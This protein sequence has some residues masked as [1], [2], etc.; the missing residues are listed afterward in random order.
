MILYDAIIRSLD[1]RTGSKSPK[2]YAYDPAKTWPEADGFD[3]L[4]QKEMAFELGGE[5][6]PSVN[7]TCVTNDALFFEGN[8]ILVY[9]EDLPNIHKAAPYA[10]IT[11]LL[12][13]DLEGEEDDR[14]AAHRAIQSMD[15]V[16]YHL[17]PKGFMMRSSGFG[18]REQVRVSKAAVREGISFE[19]VGNTFIRKYLENEN[20]R[21]VKEIFLTAP[22]ADYKGLINTAREVSNLTSSLTK[23]LDG[24]PTDCDTCSIR[25][26]CDQIDG[27]RELHFGGKAPV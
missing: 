1:G 16:K 14:E 7:F 10:R 17:Y 19:Q 6:K 25:E 9:G 26:I 4:L 5:G 13:T 12:T 2:V 24:M 22:D 8:Q 15:F 3:L 21:A 11:I 23:I 27:L 18:S 20:V